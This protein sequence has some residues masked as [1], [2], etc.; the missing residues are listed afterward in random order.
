MTF[1]EWKYKITFE[2]LVPKKTSFLNNFIV[3]KRAKM[4]F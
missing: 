3:D 2:K 4:S 1:Y